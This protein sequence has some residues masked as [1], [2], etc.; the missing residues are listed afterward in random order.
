MKSLFTL[1]ALLLTLQAQAVSLGVDAGRSFTGLNAHTTITEGDRLMLG[2]EWLLPRE[3]DVLYTAN[4]QAGYL[5]AIRP[6]YVIPSMRTSYV[7]FSGQDAGYALSPGASIVWPVL[8]T[9]WLFADYH[10][11]PDTLTLRM[12]GYQDMRLGVGTAL[13]PSL[14]MQVGYRAVKLDGQNIQPDR[15]LADGWFIGARYL[16]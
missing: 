4:L 9:V 10:Y 13:M 11:A 15:S 2:G 16:F 12:H 8:R 14:Q 5:F 7:A 3:S 6:F 1:M